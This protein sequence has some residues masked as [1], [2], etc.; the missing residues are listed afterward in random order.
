ME[1][2][3]MRKVP[4]NTDIKIFTDTLTNT[5]RDNSDL[6]QIAHPLTTDDLISFSRWDTENAYDVVYTLLDTLIT[7]DILLE[8]PNK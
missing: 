3:I 4:Y 6:L 7:I 5:L 8:F 1:H 2:P